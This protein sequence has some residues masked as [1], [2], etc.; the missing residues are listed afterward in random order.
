MHVDFSKFVK[1]N[2]TI[3]VA[4]SGGGDSMALM[5][6]LKSQEKSLGV[7]VI[8]L[9]VEHGIRGESSKNDSLFVKNYCQKQGIE[10]ITYTVDSL[11]KAREEKLSIEQSARYLRYEC[12]YDAISSGKCDKVATAH[13]LSDNAE[14]VLFNLF[15]GTGLNGIAGIKE[16]VNDKIIRPLLF[17]QKQEIEEYIAE[18]N[19]PFVTDETNYSDVY[20]RNYLRI[21]IIPEIKKIFPEAEKSIG[22]FAEIVKQD[23]DFINQSADK[24]L[25]LFE[26]KAEITLPV[27]KSVFSRAMIKALKHLSVE[28]DWEKAHVD[29]AYA[30]TEKENGCRVNL[31]KNV[32]AIKEYD[33]I[34][35]FIEKEKVNE[36][37]LFFIGKRKFGMNEIGVERVDVKTTDLK[38]GLFGDLK[39]IPQ[40]AVVRYKK[41]GD[42]FVKFGGGSK[43]LGDYLTDKKVPLRTRNQLPL[44]ANGKEVLVIFGI[45]VSDKLKADGQTTDLIKFTIGQGETL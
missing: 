33:K 22:R 34:V 31:P 38:S 13:H 12:F 29:S 10:L 43:S 35:L 3:A 40:T 4:L 1:N 14:S 7:K 45:A 18:N 16:S 30:L 6:A 25:T 41:D 42:V 23:D 28:K 24:V 32:V 26:N 15:R 2:Q 27:H 21:N 37:L 20:T 39:K 17:V 9:N 36:E 44:L 5:H 11:K 19:I 8:A